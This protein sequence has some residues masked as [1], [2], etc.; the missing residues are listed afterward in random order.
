MLVRLADKGEQAVTVDLLI[1][2]WGDP[3][4]VRSQFIVPSLTFQL[5]T[6]VAVKERAMARFYD[7][8]V[9][10][11]MRVVSFPSKLWA[12]EQTPAQLQWSDWE[13]VAAAQ[14]SGD[15]TTVLRWTH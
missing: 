2:E 4:V 6:D 5:L 8:L 9:P 13:K 12:G 3:I 11:D 7:Q 15:K 14:H 10:D 1:R